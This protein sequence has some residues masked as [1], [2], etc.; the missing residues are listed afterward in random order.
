MTTLRRELRTKIIQVLEGYG[1]FLE[2]TPP[3]ADVL[4][5]AVLGVA[6][7]SA[8]SASKRFGTPAVGR[9]S[10]EMAIKRGIKPAE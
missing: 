3:I 2:T 6:G 8:A 7:I 5:D 9:T 1:I 10:Q 4:A